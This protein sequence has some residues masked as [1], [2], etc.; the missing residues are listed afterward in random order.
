MS[1]DKELWEALTQGMKPL[2]PRQK[3]KK[4]PVSSKKP[5]SEPVKP[6]KLAKHT[7]KQIIAPIQP[8]QKRKISREQ[9]EIEA[10]LDLH[11]KTLASAQ[12]ALHRFIMESVR[13]RRRCVLVITGK[14]KEGT[15]I[16]KKMLPEWLHQEETLGH[17]AGFSPAGLRHG[18]SGAFY[19]LL[20]KRT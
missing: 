10:V 7:Q 17:I 11:G 14:G 4:L 3:A 20:K 9:R 5:E 2:H 18:G 6:L 12:P 19:L 1:E 13:Q 16:L 8:R 15:G